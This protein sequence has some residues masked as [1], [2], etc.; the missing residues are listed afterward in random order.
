MPSCHQNECWRLEAQEGC[1]GH[2]LLARA[3][4]KQGFGGSI[5]EKKKGCGSECE[6]GEEKIWRCSGEGTEQ[7][8]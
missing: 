8:S 7:K 5:L 1:F 2:H 3:V 4:K 6:R